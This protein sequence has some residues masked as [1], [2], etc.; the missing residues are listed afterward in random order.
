MES[1]LIDLCI[2]FIIGLVDDDCEGSLTKNPKPF[3]TSP[4]ASKAKK[5]WSL[6]TKKSWNKGLKSWVNISDWPLGSVPTVPM[7]IP[8]SSRGQICGVHASGLDE[9]RRSKKA[10]RWEFFP[11][12]P[13]WWWNLNGWVVSARFFWGKWKMEWRIW[14]IIFFKWGWFG[15]LRGPPQGHPSPKKSGP[16]KGQWWLIVP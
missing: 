9:R 3:E 14:P 4:W 15:N 10:P 11:V 8:P 1:K 13:W 2:F 7:V 5:T 16:I 6:V 12:K